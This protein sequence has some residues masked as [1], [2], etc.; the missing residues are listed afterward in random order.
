MSGNVTTVLVVLI[1]A[2]YLGWAAYLDKRPAR[3]ARNERSRP[4]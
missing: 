1:A 3:R 4:L 2:A